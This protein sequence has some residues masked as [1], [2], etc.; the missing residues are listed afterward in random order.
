MKI[1]QSFAGAIRERLDSIE[2]Q[3]EIGIRQEA[4]VESLKADGFENA[5]LHNLR[6]EIYRARQRRAKRAQQSNPPPKQN[7]ETEKP[8]KSDELTDSSELKTTPVVD[9]FDQEKTKDRV[10]SYFK[11]IT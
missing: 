2:R 6:N 11:K 1:K 8:R 7:V 10:K 9:A 4:I 5:N 3:L